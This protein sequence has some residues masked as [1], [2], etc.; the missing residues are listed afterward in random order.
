MGGGDMRSG[1]R[2]EEVAEE[3]EARS[4][5]PPKIFF[6]SLKICFRRFFL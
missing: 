4:Y 2:A 1:G 3:V 6:F 5:I